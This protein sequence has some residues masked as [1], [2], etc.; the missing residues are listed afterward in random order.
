[1]SKQEQLNKK[2]QEINEIMKQLEELN[3]T[4]FN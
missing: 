4:I 3:L 2:F 1:M